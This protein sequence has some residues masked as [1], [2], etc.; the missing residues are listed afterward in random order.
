MTRPHVIIRHC[1]G[2]DAEVI[3]QLVAEGLRTLDL[4]FVPDC[5]DGKQGVNEG[6][7]DCGGS[8]PTACP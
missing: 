1:A 3:R 2:Y 8:C 7:V 6:G 4:A 5:K